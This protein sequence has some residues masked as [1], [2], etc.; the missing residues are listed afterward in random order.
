MHQRIGKLTIIGQQQQAQCID[1]Q[2]TNRYPSTMMQSRQ[3]VEHRF[4]VFRVIAAGDFSERL[5]IQQ[6]ASRILIIGDHL[7][8][9]ATHDQIIIQRG[10]ITQLSSLPIEAYLTRFYPRLKLSA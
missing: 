3:T 8:I 9:H 4:T 7:V 6:D 10:T 2:P 1:I 5:V